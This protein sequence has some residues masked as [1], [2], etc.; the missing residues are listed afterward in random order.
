M[1]S[2]C[3][4]FLSILHQNIELYLD[5]YVVVGILWLLNSY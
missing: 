5:W 3:L 4:I 2:F 1:I